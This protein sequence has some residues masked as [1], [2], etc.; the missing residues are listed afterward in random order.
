MKVLATNASLPYDMLQRVTSLSDRELPDN[1]FRV[2]CKCRGIADANRKCEANGLGEKVF[3]PGWS[4]IV[5]NSEELELCK[6]ED[7]WICKDGVTGSN[8]IST[9]GL[10][11]K[12]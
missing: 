12:N 1:Q 11:S 3:L 6:A 4:Y 9:K 8:Y 7:I 5:V 2:I 10:L